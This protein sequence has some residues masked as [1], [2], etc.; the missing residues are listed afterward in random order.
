MMLAP[1]PFEPLNMS[2]PNPESSSSPRRS[3]HPRRRRKLRRKF[4]C[5]QQKSIHRGFGA[6]GLG[7]ALERIFHFS[8]CLSSLHSILQEHGF[9]SRLSYLGSR[10]RRLCPQLS[11]RTFM[12]EFCCECFESGGTL[13]GP[14]SNVGTVRRFWG[15]RWM[16][17][18][19]EQRPRERDV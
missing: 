15:P 9:S 2:N 12:L 11:R 17:R 10:K 13:Q 7:R 6:S 8:I 1:P 5:A 4:T 16:K 19:F 3:K 14:S 18:F